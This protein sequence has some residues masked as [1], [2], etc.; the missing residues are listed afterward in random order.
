L[1]AKGGPTLSLPQA[2][3]NQNAKGVPSTADR[4]LRSLGT[5]V[6]VPE[7]QCHHEVYNQFLWS[8]F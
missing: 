8:Q 2:G 4:C 3:K 5:V 6:K 1:L 7:V